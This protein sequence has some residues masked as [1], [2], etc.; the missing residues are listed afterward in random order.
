MKKLLLLAAIAVSGSTGASAANLLVNGDFEGSSSPFAT[1]PGWT[2]IGH[3]D[4][5]LSYG[6]TSQLAYNGLYFYDIG[7]AGGAGLPSIGDGITQTVATT[8]GNTYRL[9]FGYSGENGLGLSSV[10]AVT[11]G[12]IVTPFTIT[13]DNAGFFRKAFTTANIDYTATSLSTAIA[14]TLQ[15][16]TQLGDNDPLL[17][18]VS[19]SQT[20]TGAVPEPASWAMLISGFAVVG[21]SARRRRARGDSVA[22]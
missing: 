20:A 11:I 22:A 13:S 6:L 2:N 17:D 12:G 14:F 5:V 10:L 9:T 1:P 18:A 3:T 4:G 8:I 16:A 15:S 21:I 19:F 7:G